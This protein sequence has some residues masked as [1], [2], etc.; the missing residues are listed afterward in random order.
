V[1]HYIWIWIK[2]RKR[3][4]LAWRFNWTSWSA[5]TWYS[6]FKKL[7]KKLRDVPHFPLQSTMSLTFPGYPIRSFILH[8]D[9]SKSFLPMVLW[10]RCAG[11]QFLSFRSSDWSRVNVRLLLS[12]GSNPRFST[13]VLSLVVSS[14]QDLILDSVSGSPRRM[15]ALRSSKINSMV[16]RRLSLG[17]LC[18]LALSVGVCCMSN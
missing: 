12:T 11:E 2:A 7:S 16:C 5:P 4:S 3:L 18:R 10:F 17:F 15:S 14:Y 6:N 8:S 9:S 1:S 13:C